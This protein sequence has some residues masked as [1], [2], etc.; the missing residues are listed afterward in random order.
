LDLEYTIFG[1]IIDGLE[2][3]EKLSVLETNDEA[4]PKEDLEMKLIIIN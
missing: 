4:R 1:Q 3:I 2:V